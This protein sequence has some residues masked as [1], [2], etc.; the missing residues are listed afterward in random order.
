MYNFWLCG[1]GTRRSVLSFWIILSS[2]VACVTL[3]VVMAI[4]NSMPRNVL[5]LISCMWIIQY[6]LYMVG[7]EAGLSNH[8]VGR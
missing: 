1:V 3:E 6:L 4:R 8:M 5:C 2:W 7:V